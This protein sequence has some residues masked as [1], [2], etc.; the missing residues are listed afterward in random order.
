MFRTFITL[1][2]PLCL[3]QFFTPLQS[4]DAQTYSSYYFALYNYFSLIPALPIVAP[5]DERAGDVYD[6]PGSLFARKGQCF[7]ELSPDHTKTYL[8]NATMVNKSTMSAEVSAEWRAIADIAANAGV[9]LADLIR[10]S[11]GGANGEAAIEQLLPFDVVRVLNQKSNNAC[12]QELTR[13]LLVNPGD[14]V[15]LGVP[16]IIQAVWRATV[17]ISAETASV[18]DTAARGNLEKK[19]TSQQATGAVKLEQAGNRLL[20]IDAGQKVFPVAWRPAFISTTHY[21]YLHQLKDQSWFRWLAVQLHLAK[22]DQRIL[23]ELRNDFQ[24]EAYKV[25]PRPKELAVWM[26]RGPAMKFD[27][28]NKDHLAYLEHL[29]AL[30]GLSEALDHQK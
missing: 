4:A 16:W 13:R 21:G 6:V 18:V 12:R 29:D 19:L 2:V 30:I 15:S 3:I 5:Q 24:I 28:M 14:D 9:Q 8:Q 27:S 1:V 23:E 7:S 11:Y 22:S 25:V 26:S 20:V 10:I 17:N